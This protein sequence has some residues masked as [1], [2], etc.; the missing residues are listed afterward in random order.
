MVHIY[1]PHSSCCPEILGVFMKFRLKRVAIR[2]LR[3]QM[4]AYMSKVVD[5]RRFRIYSHNVEVAGLVPPEDLKAMHSLVR[6]SHDLF[7]NIIADL[8]REGSRED[9]T[10]CGYLLQWKDRFRRDDAKPILDD[11]ED[12]EN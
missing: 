6:L 7:S 2:K 8:V 12:D 1:G 9:R 5:G 10:C 4:A 11:E 3:S